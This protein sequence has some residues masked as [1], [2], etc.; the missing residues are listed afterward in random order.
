MSETQKIFHYNINSVITIR[1]RVRKYSINRVP[2]QKK[3]IN[4]VRV[5]GPKKM[6][7]TGSTVESCSKNLGP[8]GLYSKNKLN[9]SVMTRLNGLM[10]VL[11]KTASSIIIS[12]KIWSIT[13]RCNKKICFPINR[14]KNNIWSI[15]VYSLNKC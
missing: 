8:G 5:P 9:I 3:L 1:V 14:R 13:I 15:K 11:M 12:I 10:F 2:V 6:D 7:P 4:R